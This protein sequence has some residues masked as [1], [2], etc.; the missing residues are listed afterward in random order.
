MEDERRPKR[1]LRDMDLNFASRYRCTLDKDYSVYIWAWLYIYIYV[2]VQVG[3]LKNIYHFAVGSERMARMSRGAGKNYTI[4]L[5][6]EPN[7]SHA[8]HDLTVA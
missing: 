5:K 3:N 6:S 4:A 8:T 1:L 7:V 2:L